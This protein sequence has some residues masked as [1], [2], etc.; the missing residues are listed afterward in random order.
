MKSAGEVSLARMPPTFA[1]AMNTYSGRS[2]S[3]KRSNGLGG[4]GGRAPSRVRS[5]RLGMHRPAGGAGRWPIRPGRGGRRRRS[6]YL[7][8]RSRPGGT[9][10]GHDVPGVPQRVLLARQFEIVVDHRCR[11][12]PRSDMSGLPPEDLGARGSRRREVVDLGGSEVARVDG[13]RARASRA[14]RGANARLDELAR[15]CATRPSRRRSRPACLLQHQP[16]RLDV[17]AGEAPV[18]ARVEVAEVELLLEPLA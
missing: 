6:G 5:T 2:A 11:P 14:R 10:S 3:K 15:P 8:T 7:A 18:A 16:H 17:V 12:A 1:A 9:S 4:S 13:R